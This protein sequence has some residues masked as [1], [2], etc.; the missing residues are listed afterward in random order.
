MFVQSE[1]SVRPELLDTES[2][3]VYN[4]VRRNIREEER[5]EDGEAVTVYV[6]EEEKVKKEN[7]DLYEDSTQQ[8]ADIDYIAAT[9]D[10]EL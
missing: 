2:S 6:Y 10:V 7:W 4:Y 1:S 3:N 8:R 9:L 5:E